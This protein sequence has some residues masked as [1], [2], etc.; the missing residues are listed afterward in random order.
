MF[1]GLGIL[2]DERDLAPHAFELNLGS[3]DT[4]VQRLDAILNAGNLAVGI[5][6][7]SGE[8]EKLG[9]DD[10]AYLRILL[11]RSPVQ[12]GSEFPLPHGLAPAGGH[13]PP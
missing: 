2:F 5:V 3:G 13:R 11:N 7:L 8:G 12:A 4:L 9:A 10:A 1:L 6:A